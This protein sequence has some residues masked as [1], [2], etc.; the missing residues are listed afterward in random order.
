MGI[1][2]WA[3]LNSYIVGIVPDEP[4]T[5]TH[6]LSIEAVRWSIEQLGDRRTHPAFIYYLYLRRMNAL[7][8]LEEATATSPEIASLLTMPGGPENRP[9]YRPLRE[10]GNRP[11]KRL[12]SFWMQPNVSGSWSP[13]SLR[14]ITAARWLV[15][16]SD[17]Y[18][19]PDNHAA[20]AREGLLFGDPVSSVAM[21]G[22][23]LR[24]DGFILD[25]PGSAE[26]LNAAFRRK[27]LFEDSEDEFSTLFDGTLP[28]TDFAWFDE[29]SVPPT[30]AFNLP[31]PAGGE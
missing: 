13:A 12:R 17:K 6:V 11:G 28:I 10:R 31:V 25:G 30:E 5:P 23:F 16:D 2:V 29:I 1:T 26:D 27:F 15:N 4:A 8:R 14:R 24:N 20:L 3:M 21:G 18:V 22:Y 9:F 19:L 7:G